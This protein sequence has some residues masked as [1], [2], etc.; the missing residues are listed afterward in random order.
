MFRE[1]FVLVRAGSEPYLVV[2]GAVGAEIR[3]G[4]KYLVH[5]IQAAH[6]EELT[7]NSGESRS[8][9]LCWHRLGTLIRPGEDSVG[10]GEAPRC[11]S[12]LLRT[13]CAC[14]DWMDPRT[15][16]PTQPVRRPL[17]PIRGQISVSA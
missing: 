13:D 17:Q 5:H 7:E 15:H 12:A 1:K 8:A 11:R 3:L 16:A 2:V 4:T 9:Q 10:G 6:G 14:A